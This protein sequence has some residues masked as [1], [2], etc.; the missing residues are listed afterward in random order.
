[1]PLFSANLSTLFTELPFLERFA[2]ARAVGFRHVEIAF[3]Y[4]YDKNQ[5]R[6]LLEDKGLALVAFALPAGNWDKGDRGIASDPARV[7]AFRQGVERA[8]EYARALGVMRLSCLAG[9]HP[10]NF[11][12]EEATRTLI[13]N[14]A[15]AADIL[16][17]HGRTLLL[18]SLNHFDAP[19]STL[20]RTSQV[21]EVIAAAGRPN[22]AIQYDTYHAARESEDPAL[23]LGGLIDRIGHIHIAD[24]PGRHQPGTGTIDFPLFF[25]ELE[26]LGYDNYVG[27]NYLPDPG[28][29]CSLTWLKEFGQTL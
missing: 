28:T 25:A 9:L 12:Q 8:M 13:A 11:S 5:L 26:R 27:L 6:D 24:A 15:Y 3:P 22:V 1:M 19:S 17:G 14:I 10:P 20:Q 29:L 16:A 23:A 4:A 7:G 18:R 2:A 21:E